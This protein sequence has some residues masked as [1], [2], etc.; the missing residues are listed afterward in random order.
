LQDTPKDP[1]NAEQKD[2][3]ASPAQEIY[4]KSGYL[5]DDSNQ[6]ENPETLGVMVRE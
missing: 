2:K 5:G 6:P 1:S 3:N 4:R